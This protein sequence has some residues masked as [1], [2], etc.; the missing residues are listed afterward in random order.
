MTM[1]I[2]RGSSTLAFFAGVSVTVFE[3]VESG[4]GRLPLRFYDQASDSWNGSGMQKDGRLTN[5]LS[6]SLFLR[7]CE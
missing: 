5:L 4:G 2:L 7:D 3:L 6:N 1:D